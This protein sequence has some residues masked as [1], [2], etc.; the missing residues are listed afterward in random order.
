M[1]WKLLS[2]PTRIRPGDQLR[3]E[4]GAAFVVQKVL[5]TRHF[6]TEVITTEGFPVEVSDS[7]EVAIWVED[8][9]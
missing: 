8:K 6:R 9:E 7:D 5:G 4:G 2:D 1:P 3:I